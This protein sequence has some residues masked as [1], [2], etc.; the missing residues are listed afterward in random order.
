[1]ALKD[2]EQFPSAAETVRELQVII[3]LVCSK[4]HQFVQDTLVG[5]RIIQADEYDIYCCE[6][7][8]AI[9]LS[10]VRLIWFQSP[11]LYI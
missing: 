9:Q 8:Y 1:M 5:G 7:Y 4:D 6:E 3:L 10:R 2:A 11:E